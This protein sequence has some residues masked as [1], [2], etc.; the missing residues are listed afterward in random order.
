MKLIRFLFE[1]ICG[2]LAMRG[3]YVGTFRTCDSAFTFRMP[4]GWAG[5][6]NRTH[7]ASIEP[8]L[9]DPT[10][11]IA[12]YGLPVLINTANNGARTFVATDVTTPVAA[13]A[14]GARPYPI[15][16]ATATNYGATAYGSATPPPLQPLDGLKSGYI[17][18]TLQNFA[19]NNST[20]NGAVYVRIAASAGAHVQGGFEAAADNLGTNTVLLSNAYFNGPAGPDGVVEIGFNL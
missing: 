15:Q 20:K 9:I 6:V 1:Y 2:L 16:A 4:T 3:T 7:P 12:A 19:V 17:L 13:Y 10:A 14:I 8:M 18:A 5:T 11:T